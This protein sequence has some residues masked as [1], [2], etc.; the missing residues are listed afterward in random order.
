[1]YGCIIIY[2]GELAIR[3]WDRGRR[4]ALPNVHTLALCSTAFRWVIL[5]GVGL[6]E[7]DD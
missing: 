4:W 7:Y 6:P 1:M 3:E 5:V 2:L